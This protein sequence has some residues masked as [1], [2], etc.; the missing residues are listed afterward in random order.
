M[1]KHF[2]SSIRFTPLS[3]CAWKNLVMPVLSCAVC[4]KSMGNIRGTRYN[5]KLLKL[6][7]IY[8]TYTMCVLTML[9]FVSACCFGSW[10]KS[11]P[12]FDSGHGT[13]H[14]NIHWRDLWVFQ[15]TRWHSTPDRGRGAHCGRQHWNGSHRACKANS[16]ILRGWFDQ[17]TV[18][19]SWINHS[20][21]IS[22]HCT[23]P[24]GGGVC[25]YCTCFMWLFTALHNSFCVFSHPCFRFQAR[26]RVP[27]L[28]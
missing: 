27:A 24:G 21:I 15:E 8:S 13:L 16:N 11:D 20:W 3:L 25:F 14:S 23:L 22:G 12:G 9:L 10:S 2:V 6:T 19:P 17:P 5:S 26:L 4:A 28:V 1:K 7:R 18:F